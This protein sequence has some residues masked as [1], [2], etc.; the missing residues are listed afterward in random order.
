MTKEL[1]KTLLIFLLI[2]IVISIAAGKYLIHDKIIY[3]SKAQET[4]SPR[5]AIDTVQELGVLPRPENIGRDGGV[6]AAV[7]NNVLWTFGDTFFKTGAQDGQKLRSNTAALSPLT[8]PKSL[9]EPLDANNY[10]YQFIPFTQ[11]ELDYNNQHNPATDRIAIWPRSIVEFNQKGYVYYVILKIKKTGSQ[12]TIENIG[13]GVGRVEPGQTTTQRLNDSLF[14]PTDPGFGIGSTT[15]N[16]YIYSY[17]CQKDSTIFKCKITRVLPSEITKRA[18]Y[19]FWDGIKWNQDINSAKVIM[20]GPAGMMS[21]SWNQY[22]HKFLALYS[23][24]ISNKIMLSTA[25]QPQG[26][27]SKSIVAFEGE[28]PAQS[29]DYAAV[30]HREFDKDNGKTILISYDRPGSALFQGQI[31]LVEITFKSTPSQGDLVTLALKLKFQGV[32]QITGLI[33]PSVKVTLSGGGLNSDI[34]KTADFTSDSNGLFSG[35][36]IFEN[37]PLRGGYKVLIKGPMHVQKKVCKSTPTE[38]SGGFYTCATGQI[39]LTS[40][41]NNLDFSGIEFL[42]GDI[43]EQDGV[44]DSYDISFI[45]QNLGSKEAKILAKGDVNL[46]GI[47]DSQDYSLLI[48]SLSVKTDEE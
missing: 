6:S 21:V 48:A 22:L 2:F 9:K 20:Q 30:Q 41:I 19:F 12:V 33:M 47:V 15:Y 46:D 17:G 27:W 8:D 14:S 24:P 18:S 4:A 11:Q 16:G 1:K 7:G 45:R 29:Y 35:S 28:K 23:Q 40:G 42:V 25:D 3:K 32:R 43:P 13:N 34:A 10:P 37:V 36:V 5:L 26:P 38:T 31:K 39:T 44:V